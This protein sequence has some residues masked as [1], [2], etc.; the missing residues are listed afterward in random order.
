MPEAIPPLISFHQELRALARDGHVARFIEPMECLPVEKIPEGDV[1]SYE[2]KLDGYRIEAVKTGGKVTLYSRRGTDLSQR[3]A[4]VT[5][6]L[7]TLPNETVID[8]ELVALDEQGKP[9]FNLLQNFR[10]AESHIMFY[11]FDVLVRKGEGLMRTPLSKRREILAS[12]VKP[13][14][15]VGISQVSNQTAKEMVAFVK[16]HGLEG[17]IA[18]R[19]DSVYE[20]GRRSG[21]WVKRRI[22]LS[23]EFVIGG[24]VPSHLGVDSII[25]G[26]YRDKQLHY[27]ARVRAGFVPL[28]RRQVFERVKSL[29]T[30]KCP[31]VNLPEKD[32]GRWG[33]GLTAEKMKECVWVLCRMR[34]RSHNVE[35]RTMPHAL[36]AHDFGGSLRGICTGWS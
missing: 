12:T 36:W 5:A 3:F 19:T 7:A 8:G 10:S 11:A 22:N 21:L 25:I 4:Y 28:T 31:F 23:Q 26:L 6:A 29:E 9:N 30:A 33:Q 16:S 14:D 20:P 24:Y 17:I 15:H 34:H 35:C 2:L 32:A 1:W 27:A 13:H 18:K